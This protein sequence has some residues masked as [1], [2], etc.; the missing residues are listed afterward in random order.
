[1]HGP[2]AAKLASPGHQFFQ[3]IFTHSDAVETKERTRLPRLVGFEGSALLAGSTKINRSSDQITH[4]S[5][6]Q[7]NPDSN[8]HRIKEICRRR[9]E[10]PI[11]VGIN[12]LILYST[13]FMKVL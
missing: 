4:A 5:S 12:A 3:S 2:L 6:R 1:M 11:N 10:H 8:Q 13:H 7:V 9:S